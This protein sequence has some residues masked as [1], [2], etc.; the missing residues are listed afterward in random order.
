M[1]R[2][3][4]NG[5]KKVYN[6]PCGTGFSSETDKEM[7]VKLK[8]HRKFC[9]LVTQDNL[10]ASSFHSTDSVRGSYLNFLKESRKKRFKIIRNLTTVVSLRDNL[11][12]DNIYPH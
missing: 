6:C 4:K 7:N 11:P 10:K 5:F 9:S 12:L 3:F 8:L 1:Y 2:N